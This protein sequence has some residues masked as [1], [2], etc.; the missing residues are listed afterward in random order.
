MGEQLISI[1]TGTAVVKGADDV[2]EAY[3]YTI[4]KVVNLLGTDN[5]AFDHEKIVAK[6]LQHRG[7]LND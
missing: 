2:L 3:P 5:F 1:A 7:Y 6:Y 4:D